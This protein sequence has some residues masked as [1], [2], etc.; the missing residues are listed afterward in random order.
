[1]KSKSKALLCSVPGKISI[2]ALWILAFWTWLHAARHR[3][4]I[5][6]PFLIRTLITHIVFPSFV[7]IKMLRVNGLVKTQLPLVSMG[8]EAGEAQART[9]HPIV[10]VGIYVER[11]WK[12]GWL[13]QSAAPCGKYKSHDGVQRRLGC[14]VT[15]ANSHERYRGWQGCAKLQNPQARAGT[16]CRPRGVRLYHPLANAKAR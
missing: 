3:A 7:V 11:V 2:P 8:S 5:L 14:I 13:G 4:S 15:P 16:G 6:V 9:D 1:M 10:S 12:Q